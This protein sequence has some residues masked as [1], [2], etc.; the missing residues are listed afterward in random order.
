[1][2]WEQIQETITNLLGLAE[3]G[4]HQTMEFMGDAADGDVANLLV[5]AYIRPAARSAPPHALHLS[6]TLLHLLRS[7]A[8]AK[9]ALPGDEHCV[10]CISWDVVRVGAAT[11]GGDPQ[12]T[13]RVL[14]GATALA[15]RSGLALPAT[16]LLEMAAF[17]RRHVPQQPV[18]AFH[19]IAALAALSSAAVPAPLALALT[20]PALAP[21]AAQSLH[22]Y[23]QLASPCCTVSLTPSA[24]VHPHSRAPHRPTL[25]GPSSRSAPGAQRGRSC[26]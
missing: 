16:P 12:A 2:R 7:T 6:L 17:I 20:S 9:Y 23:A 3:E 14:R 22:V 11:V 25:P 24:R 1:L 21:A 5:R 19:T 15:E 26:G 13:A 4:A 8:R 10:I 18:D